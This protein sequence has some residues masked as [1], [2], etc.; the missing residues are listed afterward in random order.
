MSS[1]VFA[2]NTALRVKGLVF[3]RL[4]LDVF[5]LQILWHVIPIFNMCRLKHVNRLFGC[6]KWC[7]YSDGMR[8]F[9]D[10]KAHGNSFFCLILF[11]ANLTVTH[12]SVGP[13]TRTSVI[14]KGLI[15][16]FCLEKTAFRG[17]GPCL[18]VFSNKQILV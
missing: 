8:C 2:V 15:F 5:V 14:N 9:M 17:Q 7:F 6:L 10:D 13:F 18:S 11:Y 4:F 1:S 12:K 3:N 16:V